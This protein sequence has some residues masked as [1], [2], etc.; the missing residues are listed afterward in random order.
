MDEKNKKKLREVL[1]MYYAQVTAVDVEIGRIQKGLKELGVDD[2]T[3]IIYVSDHGDVLGSNNREIVKK[4]IEKNRNLSNTIRT[5]GKPF[6][7]AFR[8]PLII[9]GP[10]VKTAGFTSDALVSSVDLVPTILDLA[11]IEI[12]EYMQGTSMAGWVTDN[13]GPVQ[14][15]L[16]IGLSD[17]KDAWRAVWDGKYMLSMLDYKLFYDYKNDPFETNNLY[18]SPEATEKQKEYE[19]ALINLAEK[20]GDPILPRLKE[21]AL[22]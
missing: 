13:S 18:A 20:T 2:N 6:S 1:Q 11:G 17:K 15:Y 8:I 9:S 3:I 10:G 22:N 7:T 12:P 21:A 19:K 16:Y 14:P 4:Y 5:K